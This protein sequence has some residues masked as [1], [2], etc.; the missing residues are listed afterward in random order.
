MKYLMIVLLLAG[1]ASKPSKTAKA[2]PEQA[3]EE[4][5]ATYTE[6]VKAAS[7]D[8]LGRMPCPRDGAW[9][10]QDW[11]KIIPMANGCV[12]AKDWRKV[13]NIGAYLGVH[14]H[15]TPWGAYY[16]SV[17]AGARKDYPRAVWMMEL[18]LKKAPGEGLFHYQLGRMHWEMEDD[19]SALKHLKMAS[20]MNPTLTDAHWVMGQIALQRGEMNQAQ[21]LLEKALNNEPTH[22]GAL[23]AMA[24]LKSK[25][26]DLEGA[27]GYLARAV[28]SNP[29]HAPARKALSD[30]QMKMKAEQPQVSKTK[31]VSSRKPAEKKVSE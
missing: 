1:C 4:V 19:T 10:G 5:K 27:E 6:K 17:A 29:R 21:E 11:R 22:F 2:A 26:K 24:S 8:N 3:K 7:L 13:E 31:K 12:K 9:N 16:M 14:A 25:G 28:R 18:A 15:L 23:M 20:E 30:I